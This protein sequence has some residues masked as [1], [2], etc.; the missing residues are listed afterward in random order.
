MFLM[1]IL[2]DVAWWC[3]NYLPLIKH[4]FYWFYYNSPEWLFDPIYECWRLLTLCL[5]I[6]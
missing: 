2:G 1:S 6:I 3:A 4:C 5:R